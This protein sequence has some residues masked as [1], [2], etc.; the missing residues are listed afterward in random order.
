M[1]PIAKPFLGEEEKKAVAQVIESGVIAE[2]PKVAEFEKAFAKYVG[3]KYAVATST[4]TSALHLALLAAGVK[5]KDEVVLPS[6]SFVASANTVVFCQ[7]KPV[8][9]DIEEETYTLDV[10]EAKEKITGKT[11]AIIPVHLYGH[12][13]QMDE[14]RELADERGLAVIEDACQ[15]HGAGYRGKKAGSLG[16]AGCFSFYPSKNMTTGEGG[17]ITTDNE[18]IAEYTRTLRNHGRSVDGSHDVLGFNYRMTDL[19]AAIGLIQLRRLEGFNEKRIRN[20]EYLTGK[21][22]GIDW[23]KTPAVKKDCRHVFHQYTI[24]VDRRGR[25]R[26]LEILQEKSVGA[27]VYYRTPIHKQELYSDKVS[28]PVT[29]DC[30]KSVLSLPIH[31]Q[32]SETELDFIAGTLKSI[33]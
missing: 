1:I 11:K 14:I 31:P 13:A 3:T 8:F 7:A 25:D 28:L 6:F 15:A 33:R 10:K 30:A 26:V 12:P 24:K 20:A 5:E 32:V 17:M 18:E 19:A 29:E 27:A 9:A 22:E 4:G 16:D 23:I 21:L 2:G